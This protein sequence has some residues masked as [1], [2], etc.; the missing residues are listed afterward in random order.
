MSRIEVRPVCNRRIQPHWAGVRNGK[1]VP[2][3]FQQDMATTL[4]QTARYRTKE[5]FRST[6][7]VTGPLD[8][9]VWR[10]SGHIG[11]MAGAMV[12]RVLTAPATQ[13]SSTSNPN[14]FLTLTNTSG[15]TVA[16]GRAHFGY[17][18]GLTPS[19]VPQEWGVATI[20]IDTS[21]LRDTSFRAVIQANE[22]ARPIS[23]TVY[24]YSL[25][26]DTD[27]GYVNQTY[28]VGAPILDEDRWRLQALAHALYKRGGPILFDFSTDLDSQAHTT[29]QWRNVVDN[30]VAPARSANST[31]G[32]RIDQ[33]SCN[34]KTKTT[35]PARVD[36]LAQ[37]SGTTGGPG[38]VL[39]TREDGTNI[40]SIS[41]SSTT[42]I[43]HTATVNFPADN[44]M[45]FAE[46]SGSGLDTITTYAVSCYRYMT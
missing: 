18:F 16:T 4:N 37:V 44:A 41:V 31:P 20:G 40:A 30:S 27:N 2:A 12:V 36:V 24:E 14:V 7:D 10:F 32:F 42:A 17:S 19:E 34:R 25:P 11:P 5:Y 29:T 33:G 28:P 43:W 21:S 35:V 15:V 22:E 3:H 39:I 38:S 8:D 9:K 1:L 46:Q 6:G 26:G 45:Y 13:L 23:C